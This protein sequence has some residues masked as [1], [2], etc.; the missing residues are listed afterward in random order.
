ME[1]PI[2]PTTDPPK[3]GAA[4][5]PATMEDIAADTSGSRVAEGVAETR[6]RRDE[7]IGWIEVGSCEIREAKELSAGLTAI[8]PPVGTLIPATMDD[9]IDDILGSRA[10]VGVA[11][12]CESSEDMIGLIEVGS[13]GSC[14]L[15]ELSAEPTGTGPAAG[16]LM[17]ATIDEMIEEILGSRV[18][19]GVADT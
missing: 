5:T 9:T 1:P 7:M 3:L 4:V 18:A 2:E 11:E 10:A 6:D 12:I 13:C 14:E 15:K 17:P 19:E 8:G 16:V